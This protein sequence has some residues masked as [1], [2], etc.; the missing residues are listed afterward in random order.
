M[1]NWIKWA[2][3]T[4]VGLVAVGSLAIYFA[5]IGSLP[6]LDGNISSSAVGADVKIER[7]SLGHAV[8]S[9]DTLNDAVFGLGYAH[10]QDRLF[11]MDAQ[12]RAA[13]GEL[14]EWLGK[15]L[16]DV[17]KR[18]RFHQFRKRAK[19]IVANLPQWQKDVLDHYAAGVNQ[20]IS[21]MSVLPFEYLL[22]Q[23]DVSPWQPEDSVLVA[24]SMYM[25]LQAGQVDRDLALSE[26]ERAYGEDMV[27]FLTQPSQYQSAYDGSI[28][29]KSPEIPSLTPSALAYLHIEEPLDIGSNNWA[30][31]GALTAT[32]AGMLANDMHLGL[33]VPIIWY[34][35]QINY[36][37]NGQNVQVTGV[38]LPGLPGVVVGTNDYIAWGFTNAN[39]DNVDWI[40]LDSDTPSQVEKEIIKTPDGDVQFDIEM[41][42]FGPVKTIDSKR[43]ALQWVAHQPYAVDLDI[44]EL[45]VKTSIEQ[46]LPVVHRIGI[47][48]QNVT[49]VD[50]HGNAS[51][52]PG[53]AVTA[54]KKPTMSA[55]PQSAY[56]ALWKEDETQLP[57]NLNPEHGRIWTGNARVISTDDLGRFGDGGYAMGARQ[58]QIRDRMFEFEEFDEARF[59]AI[60]LDNEA[61]FI[62]RWHERLLTLLKAS[63]KDYSID[64]TALENWGK[65]AC[66]ESVGYTLARRFRS[67]VTNALLSPLANQLEE[68]GLSLSPV[69]RHTEPAIRTILEQ[70]PD[71]WLP[72]DF[73]DW[74]SFLLAQYDDSKQQLV[75]E[76]GESEDLSSL[77]WG[78]V[79][80]LKVQHPIAAQLPIVGKHLNMVEYPGFG[81]SY[82][83][84]VQGPAFGASERLFVQPGHL[85]KA[86]LTLPGGQSGH[87]L[88]D[89]YRIGFDD[90]VEQRQTPLLPQTIVHTLTITPAG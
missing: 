6:S 62:E 11:Q 53:G 12:R 24:F 2:L 77:R 55:I 1:L 17:D 34:R 13:A 58:L 63:D 66:P 49:M 19:L 46:A 67:Q 32:Q 84:A 23:F 37:E 33:R 80:A 8:V 52:T 29:V 31:T 74:Q 75:E 38:T 87:P 60:Q 70:Q 30:V 56:S 4:L 5:L 72:S 3:I 16:L 61:R 26:I 78:R 73:S 59:Y 41:S 90:Y 51:W 71:N 9:A 64:I 18:A 50:R 14:S 44:M 79:N 83:P 86:I 57:V 88:S 85:D 68:K 36:Q 89:Y 43:Y 81:D 28:D 21:E 45:G 82:M 22:T 42:E 20:A 7:D 39:L 27:A 76:F 69:L 54:R 35:G 47:P 15:G 65:C 40:V 48:V 10:A 25:S